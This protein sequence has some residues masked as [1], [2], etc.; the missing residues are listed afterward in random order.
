MHA[1][2]SSSTVSRA[3]CRRRMRSIACSRRRAASSTPSSSSRWTRASCSNASRSGSRRRRRGARR[4]APTMIRR[5]C[6]GGSWPTAIRPRRSPP[7]TSFRACCARST[8]WRRSRRWEAPSIGC[9]AVRP[10]RSRRRGRRRNGPRPPRAR[11]ASTAVGER[12]PLGSKT[13]PANR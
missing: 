3:R 10:S 8:A 6:T 1:G 2:A 7:I 9:F 13:R 12:V 4:C 11:T 5:C